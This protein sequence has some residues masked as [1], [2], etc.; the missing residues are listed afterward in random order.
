M[1]PSSVFRPAGIDTAASYA[2]SYAPSVAPSTTSRRSRVMTDAE[3]G[4]V[5]S[6]ATAQ[7]MSAARSIIMTG[8]TQS[9]ALTTAKAAA[10]SV[11]MPKKVGGVKPP[12]VPAQRGFFGRKKSKQQAEIIASMALV[13]VNSTISQQSY[14]VGSPQFDPMGMMV[15]GG[16][17]NLS[18]MG[19]SDLDDETL[20]LKSLKQR[21]IQTPP[22][23]RSPR[24][25]STMVLE[26]KHSL[27]QTN[28]LSP[29]NQVLGPVPTAAPPSPTK[30]ASPKKSKQSQALSPTASSPKSTKSKKAAPKSPSNPTETNRPSSPARSIFRKKDSKKSPVAKDSKKTPVAAPKK[31]KSPTKPLVHKEATPIPTSPSNSEYFRRKEARADETTPKK[32]PKLPSKM[33]VPRAAKKHS[34]KKKDE[35]HNISYSSSYT[36]SSGQSYSID[37]Y[38]ESSDDSGYAGAGPKKKSNLALFGGGMD[39]FLTTISEAFLCSPTKTKHK[40]SGYEGHADEVYF[41]DE[42][43]DDYKGGDVG[44]ESNEM[45]KEETFSSVDDDDDDVREQPEPVAKQLPPSSPTQPSLEPGSDSNSMSMEQ[46]VLRALSATMPSGRPKLDLSAEPPKA[47]SVVVRQMARNRSGVYSPPSMDA[48]PNDL[49]GDE[50]SSKS[51]VLSSD[52]TSECATD[53]SRKLKLPPW[54]RRGKGKKGRDRDIIRSTRSARSSF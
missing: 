18:A 52:T 12:L 53:D 10:K 44:C 13:S 21:S 46:L 16:G 27:A 38:S 28:C 17:S 45:R 43:D 19:N 11:L 36:N 6:Q 40:T 23:H 9:T 4:E 15:H 49:C 42:R 5:L 1:D 30:L 22:Q 48:N 37:V 35:E 41:P 24:G 51:M 26:N 31:E 14:S 34:H 25:A 29:I 2:P 33:P 8:G 32:A 20:T 47:K 54:L 39:P 50:S 7:A 3:E